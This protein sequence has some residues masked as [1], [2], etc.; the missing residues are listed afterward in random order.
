MPEKIHPESTMFFNKEKTF[1]KNSA[2]E[3][4]SDYEKN[5]IS[6]SDIFINALVDYLKKEK[7]KSDGN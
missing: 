5:S 7:D 2:V 4:K 1:Y 3:L 6:E